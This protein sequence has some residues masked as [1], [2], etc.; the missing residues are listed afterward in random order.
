M[1]WLFDNIW[2]ADE[3]ISLH[4]TLVEC[5]SAQGECVFVLRRLSSNYTVA[6]FVVFPTPVAI[7]WLA[8]FHSDL[9]PII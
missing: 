6:K 7:L 8:M 2:A 3:A 4:T 9:L 1:L 5:S